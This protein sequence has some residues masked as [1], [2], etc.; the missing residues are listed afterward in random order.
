[1]SSWWWMASLMGGVF[2]SKSLWI[3][4]CWSLRVTRMT[5]AI[6][7]QPSEMFTK[8]WDR[9]LHI[10]KE[11]VH[12]IF[13]QNL[14]VITWDRFFH[15]A[16]HVKKMMFFFWSHL[17]DDCFFMVTSSPSNS[18]TSPAPAGGH[19][20]TRSGALLEE[21]GWELQEFY[22]QV[23]GYL[24]PF[25]DVFSKILCWW[26]CVL[27]CGAAGW[28]G[29]NRDT[30]NTLQRWELSWIGVVISSSCTVLIWKV[31]PLN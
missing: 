29:V 30:Q 2:R 1:M 21:K 27:F 22:G 18:V 17:F 23:C 11:V 8:R 24:G 13:V 10:Y 19:Y 26:G 4:R 25:G 9:L 20:P 6:I 7:F 15:S 14:L 31:I 28:N 12:Q 5:R 16:W 3:E